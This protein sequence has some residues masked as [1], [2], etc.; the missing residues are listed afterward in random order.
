L[1]ISK[2]WAVTD[3]NFVGGTVK[4]KFQGRTEFFFKPNFSQRVKTNKTALKSGLNCHLT[5]FKS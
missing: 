1:I 5:Q 4:L 2:F 3:L